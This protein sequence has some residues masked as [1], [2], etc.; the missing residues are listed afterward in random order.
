[1]TIEEKLAN[2]ILEVEKLNSK[3][4]AVLMDNLEIAKDNIMLKFAK[5]S[6]QRELRTII[7]KEITEAFKDMDSLILEDIEI[8]TSVSWNATSAVLVQYFTKDINKK[9]I[10]FE[11]LN[12]IL[13]KQIL[14]PNRLILGNNLEDYKNNFIY[15]A[16]NKLRS[17]IL[18]GAIN[19]DNLTVITNK[20]DGVLKVTKHQ[21]KTVAHT[22]TLSAINESK[23]IQYEQMLKGVDFS[24]KYSAYLDGRT[25]DYCKIAHGYKTKNLKIAKYRPNSH[26]S[27]RSL[28]VITTPEI[29]AYEKRHSAD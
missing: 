1:M 20:L 27:C 5:T 29:E 14:N 18:D 16:N 7:K 6:N 21:L 26:Y 19:N 25:S 13:K 28:W 8:A 17:I 9:F 4:V 15:S 11:R 22:A 12:H 2:T 23:A 24:Y 10:K 3:T